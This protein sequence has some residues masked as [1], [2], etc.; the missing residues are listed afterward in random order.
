MIHLFTNT[1]AARLRVCHQFRDNKFKLSV[2]AAYD[3]VDLLLSLE[4]VIGAPQ[5]FSLFGIN[6]HISEVL[7]PYL[8]WASGYSPMTYR[9]GARHEAIDFPAMMSWIS[10]MPTEE[11]Q[12]T[13]PEAIRNYHGF[14]SCN[15][16]R[17]I[18]R[19]HIALQKRLG[20]PVFV[21][22]PSPLRN[23]NYLEYRFSVG[24]SDVSNVLATHMAQKKI[25]FIPKRGDNSNQI[26]T[27]N[28]DDRAHD[29][30]LILD[31]A[32][33]DDLRA[34]S[35]YDYMP[36]LLRFLQLLK[37]RGVKQLTLLTYF[38]ES[39][40]AQTRQKDFSEYCEIHAG[41]IAVSQ[42]SIASIDDMTTIA[43]QSQSIVSL[44]AYRGAQIAYQLNRTIFTLCDSP[45]DM[46]GTTGADDL[47][48][49]WVPKSQAIEPHHIKHYEYVLKWVQENYVFHK[50]KIAKPFF[51]K[52]IRSV[53]T[54]GVPRL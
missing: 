43:N 9:N 10:D 7:A 4:P 12:I 51:N 25:N 45:W 49:G 14:I 17:L 23:M 39:Q 53:V 34:G 18:D 27:D 6:I 31:E 50:P 19:F 28:P 54:Y 22:A 36:R 52:I 21:L 8:D 15:A 33:I 41:D 24:F 20:K 47:K 16:A 40:T 35:G 5:Y 1:D 29:I 13:R 11:R 44:S 3:R 46:F 37:N 30:C 32:E 42:V 48:L 38:G 26:E 2:P